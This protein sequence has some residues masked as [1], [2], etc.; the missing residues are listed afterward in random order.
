[1]AVDD[2]FSRKAEEDAAL[3]ISPRQA[4]R[5]PLQCLVAVWPDRELS[6]APSGGGVIERLNKPE[7]SCS[8]NVLRAGTARGPA[9]IHLGGT[10]V[11]RPV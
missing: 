9:N 10:D 2:L 5:P 3:P 8:Q 11:M 7:F 6:L 1:M 4:R